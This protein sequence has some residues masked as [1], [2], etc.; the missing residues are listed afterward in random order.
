LTN[1]EPWTPHR[2]PIVAGFIILCVC[3][4][5]RT[6]L[7]LYASIVYENTFNLLISYTPQN[8]SEEI[9]WALLICYYF[10]GEI[11]SLLSLTMIQY[12]LPSD[13]FQ[14]KGVGEL[15]SLIKKFRQEDIERGKTDSEWEEKFI[16]KICFEKESNSVLLPCNHSSLC[17]ECASSIT[18][19][20]ICRE[21]VSQIIGPIFRG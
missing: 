7:L 12:N 18:I 17:Y 21:E 9:P 5:V 19:C 10:V 3:L 1:M 20:P 15:E 13:L 8:N 4:L 11:L 2:I 16:C 6:F 14:K